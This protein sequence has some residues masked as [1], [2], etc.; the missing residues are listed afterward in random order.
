MRLQY[1]PTNQRYAFT[2]GDALIRLH[3]ADATLYAWREHAIAD[4]Q[5]C[6]LVVD[7]EGEVMLREGCHANV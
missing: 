6:G 4:A 5:L 3:V 2:F 7:D 1:L